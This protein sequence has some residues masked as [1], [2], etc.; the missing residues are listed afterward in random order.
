MRQCF[1]S[2]MIGLLLLFIPILFFTLFLPVTTYAAAFWSKTYGS[3]GDDFIRSIVRTPDGGYIAAGY[4]TSFSEGDADLWVVKLDGAGDVQW[5]KTY[6]GGGVDSART[7]AL[8]S[9]DG[10][11]IAGV[12][13]SFGKGLMDALVVKLGPDGST[14]WEYTYGGADADYAR[15]IQQVSD[16]GYI[17]AGWTS[18]FETGMSDAWMLKLDAAGQVQWQKAYGREGDDQART[19]QSTSDGGYIVT[20]W[21]SSFG[22]GDFDAWILKLDASGNVQWQKTFGGYRNDYSKYVLQT[23][24]G[25]YVVAGWTA[26]FGRG[27]FDFWV[28][29]LNSAGTIEWEKTYGHTGTDQ[30]RH[31]Q[32]TSDGGYIVAGWSNS[33][34]AGDYDVLTLKLDASGNIVWQSAYGDSGDDK[35]NSVIQIPDGG[36]VVAAETASFGVMSNDSWVLKVD[37]N[38]NIGACP[39][40]YTPHMIA[41]TSSAMIRNTGIA[42][43]MTDAVPQAES[44]PEA[45]I[46]MPPV[47][48][49]SDALDPDITVKPSFVKLGP[50]RNNTSSS[51]TVFIGNSGLSG[52][53]IRSIAIAERYESDFS[54][55]N[56]CSTV[57]P[58]SFCEITVTFKPLSAGRQDALLKVYSNDP[59]E[60]VVVIPMRGAGVE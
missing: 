9:D 5:Q 25:G 17:V 50:V 23:S 31:I 32:Q 49:C 33:F 56:T 24:D 6:G 40:K 15:Y 8:A 52:L 60:G 48:L 36:Y 26:S 27:D 38:G 11:I 28:F 57:T 51:E 54:Q 53:I 13:D 59:D 42:G 1:T 58:D 43:I 20:G 21:T 30:A 10:Y 19:V 34:G 22:N 18:S 35:S 47:T 37:G 4:T 3:S 29:K 39:N 16:G 45:L 41:G 12:T 55:S 44:I 46:G 7:L 14:Q 2:I